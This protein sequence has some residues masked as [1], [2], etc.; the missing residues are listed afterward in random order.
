MRCIAYIHLPGNHIL[1]TRIS[2]AGFHH[3]ALLGLKFWKFPPKPEHT[4]FHTGTQEKVPPKICRENPERKRQQ[5]APETLKFEKWYQ[6]CFYFVWLPK[7]IPFAVIWKKPRN[8]QEPFRQIPVW[9]RAGWKSF[10]FARCLGC[11]VA[12]L[13]DGATP[14]LR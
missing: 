4:S 14:R 10:L 1:V 13:W 12:V 11:K 5:K 8:P 7:K 2:H 6:I 3:L 9:L